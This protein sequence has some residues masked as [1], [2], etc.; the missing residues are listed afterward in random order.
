MQRAS[1]LAALCGLV[2]VAGCGG[3]ASP[4][5]DAPTVATGTPTAAP[6]MPALCGDLTVRRVGTVDAP[7]AT[8][9]SG[10]ALS[11]SGTLWAHNDSGDVPRV[12]ALDRR[13]RFQREVAVSGAEAVD[14]EDIAIRGRTLYVGDIGDNLAQRPNVS[15]YRFAE[16][17]AGATGVTA[18]RIDLRYADGPHDAETLLVDP[19]TG[20]IV[21]VTKDIGGRSG[22]YVA[23]KGV[24]R[25]RA[26]LKL[27]A[28]QLLTAGDVSGDGR[29]IV[30]R[31]YG[32]AFV[33]ERHAG[34]SLPRA[35]KRAPCTADA[36]LILE[37]Q[38]ESLALT[39]DGRAFYTLP[40]GPGPT[41]RRYAS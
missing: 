28:G 13:G 33:Y 34:E 5:P 17:P 38:G 8:E 15:V 19:R 27:G 40:E 1:R 37:G 16:P 22:V 18:T 21:V 9:V 26:T 7:A 11:R 36:N 6:A 25:R 35:L 24:L 20:A 32:R 39:R 12:L 14:W 31:S 29:T 41:L 3:S 23:A 10:L 30:L 4:P 2:L